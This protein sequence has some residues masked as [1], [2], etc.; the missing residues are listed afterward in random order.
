LPF[1]AKKIAN[2]DHGSANYFAKTAGRSAKLVD[3]G[4]VCI[5][6]WQPFFK[7]RNLRDSNVF[8]FKRL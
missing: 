5:Y 2:S 7:T 4:P 1:S 8:I 3:F 6:K